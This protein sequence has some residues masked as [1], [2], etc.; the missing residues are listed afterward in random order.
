MKIQVDKDVFEDP[1]YCSIS[2]AITGPA[3]SCG[4]S[5]LSLCRAF[6]DREF[7][8][9]AREYDHIHRAFKKCAECKTAYQKALKEPKEEIQNS[10]PKC[11]KDWNPVEEFPCPHCGNEIP[12]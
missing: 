3:D 8:P 9:I 12:F 2:G 5:S 11:R 4:H 6:V 10:C 1:E 7:S